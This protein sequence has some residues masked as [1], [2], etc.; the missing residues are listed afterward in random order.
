MLE[1]A[2]ATWTAGLRLFEDA[3]SSPNAAAQREIGLC[4]VV[5]SHL[6]TCVSLARFYQ[7]R[8]DAAS[9]GIRDVAALQQRVADMQAILD[10]E[11]VNA[12]TVLPI[13]E[14]DDRVGYGFCYW[15]VYDARM[16]RDKIDQCR[17]VR[18]TELPELTRG[19]RFHLFRVFP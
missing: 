11:I 1:Q 13:L 9:H 17:Y 19:L 8:D 3:F 15:I 14:R 6:Q 12:E 18:D 5:K 16:V 7:L 10:A 2:L 4:R